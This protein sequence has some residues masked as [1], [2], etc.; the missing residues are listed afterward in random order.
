MLKI[1]IDTNVLI[2]AL[3]D[4]HSYTWRILKLVEKGELQAV[5]SDK[6]IQEYQLVIDREVNNDAD[7]SE[8]QKFISQ[9]EIVPVTQ[10]VR[11]VRF[12]PEDDKFINLALSAQAA[13]IVSS[14]SHLLEIGSYRDIKILKP[15]NFYYLYQGAADSDGQAAWADIF[16]GLFK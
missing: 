12:D 16:R 6:I 3:A 15:I 14:D 5:A 11:V 1:V 8:L 9:V 4:R 2:D 10:H 7:K 13:Y